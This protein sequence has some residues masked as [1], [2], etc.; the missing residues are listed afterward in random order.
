MRTGCSRADADKQGE[1]RSWLG[2]W[3]A[4]AVLGG[5][6]MGASDRADGYWDKEELPIS[7]QMTWVLKIK[8][9]WSNTGT[10]YW[11]MQP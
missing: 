2:V 10:K 4:F 1:S 5:L 6:D 11:K 9:E 8:V 7:L 3:Q